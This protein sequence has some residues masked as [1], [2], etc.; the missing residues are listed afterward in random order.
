MREVRY[1]MKTIKR[2]FSKENEEVLL[3]RQDMEYLKETFQKSLDEN[4]AFV[5]CSKLHDSMVGELY[6]KSIGKLLNQNNGYVLRL[7]ESMQLVGNATIIENMLE[8]VEVQNHALEQMKQTSQ[9]LGTAINNISSVVQD[10]TCN[11]NNAVEVSKNSVTRMTQSVEIAN[12]SCEDFTKI[13]QMIQDFKLRTSKVNDIID[14]VKSIAGQTNLLSLNAAIEAARAG[15]SGKGFAVV[16]SEVKKLSEGTQKSTDDIALYIA[17]LQRDID[18]L[19]VTIEKTSTQV[20]NGNLGV[21]QSILDIQ[22]IHESIRSIDQ[23]ILQINLQ[24]DEQNQ[25]TKQVVYTLEQIATQSNNLKE[26]CTGVGQ[27]MFKLSRSVD[28]VRGNI[29]RFASN[30]SDREWIEIFKIDHIIFTWRVFNHIYDFESLSLNNI[31]NPNTCKLGKW[32][33]SENAQGYNH[34]LILAVKQDHEALHRKV[35]ES[36][37]AKT[38]NNIEQ[39]LKCFNEAK[40]ILASLLHNL[41]KIR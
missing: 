36:Y 12:K 20:Q 41:D 32:Y 11:V 33:N 7:N 5:D 39:A 35:V 3:L 17:E 15:E 8:S 23:D 22:G 4:Y 30:L 37:D 29:A 21:Q 9:N 2:F 28:S 25:S 1:I 19:V 16:A 13:T 24:V 34:A 31:N 38:R 27:L 14:I 40:D 10:V 26:C 6:N 18:T